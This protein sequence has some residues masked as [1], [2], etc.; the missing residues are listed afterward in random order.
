MTSRNNLRRCPLDKALEDHTSK[1]R[2]CGNGKIPPLRCR[3]VHPFFSTRGRTGGRPPL[4]E[5]SL[6]RAGPLAS[7]AFPR[8][9]ITFVIVTN[10]TTKKLRPRR[11]QL[12]RPDR[13][14]RQL[15]ASSIPF[16]G[17]RTPGPRGRE[18]N[19]RQ[20]HVSH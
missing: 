9:V 17:F 8:L 12:W 11:R 18:R 14:W 5:T 1:S 16:V 19:C 15:Y 20:R 13:G 2:S 10:C 3:E 7:P 6:R 4:L